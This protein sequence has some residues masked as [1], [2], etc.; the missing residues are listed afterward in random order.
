[1]KTVMIFSLFDLAAAAGHR[2]ESLNLLCIRSSVYENY[3]VHLPADMAGQMIFQS[4]KQIIE[5]TVTS[6]YF[7]ICSGP[8]DT[9]D[10][11]SMTVFLPI[12]LAALILVIMHSN[13]I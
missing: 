2:N 11:E 9:S 8:A 12:L 13:S 6:V 7:H 5:S 4:V 1:M 3:D 10:I